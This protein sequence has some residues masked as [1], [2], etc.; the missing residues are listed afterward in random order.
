M[1][2]IQESHVGKQRNKYQQWKL[3]ILLRKWEKILLLKL[4]LL[5]VETKII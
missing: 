3:Y 4:I 2:K 5:Y 1:I